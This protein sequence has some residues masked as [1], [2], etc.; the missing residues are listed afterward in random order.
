MPAWISSEES[1]D[2]QRFD[3]WQLQIL[4]LTHLRLEAKAIFELNCYGR[5]SLKWQ[6]FENYFFKSIFFQFNISAFQ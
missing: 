3:A 4:I 6:F 2:G 5:K 1:T